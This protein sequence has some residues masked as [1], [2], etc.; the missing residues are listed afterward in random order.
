MKKEVVISCIIILF[1][2]AFMFSPNSSS[3]LVRKTKGN[4]ARI[5]FFTS[6]FCHRCGIPW[7]MTEKHSTIYSEDRSCFALCE[8]CWGELTPKQR[9]S[10]YRELWQSGDYGNKG[11]KPTLKEHLANWEDIKSAV[12]KGL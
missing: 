4:I 8:Q 11:D 10:H 6:L 12:L 2:V 7:H 5:V 3:V 9:L 1:L